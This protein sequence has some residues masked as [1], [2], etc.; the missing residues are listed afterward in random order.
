MTI[1]SSEI[2]QRFALEGSQTRADL[3]QCK[4]N[5]ADWIAAKAHSFSET[6]LTLL[7]RLGGVL[8]AAEL[9]QKWQRSW[10]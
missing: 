2:R 9:E 10:G 4:A 8:H 6:D 1:N 3:G 7:V 5:F